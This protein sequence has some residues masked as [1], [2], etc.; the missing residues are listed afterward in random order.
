MIVIAVQCRCEALMRV[1]ADR[2]PHAQIRQPWRKTYAWAC[3]WLRY[4]QNT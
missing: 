4:P 2:T 1:V 3:V